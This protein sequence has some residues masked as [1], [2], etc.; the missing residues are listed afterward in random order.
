M[1]FSAERGEVQGSGITGLQR[2][3]ESVLERS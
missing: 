1:E 2:K 3:C